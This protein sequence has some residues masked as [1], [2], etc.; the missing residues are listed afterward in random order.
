MDFHCPPDL[1]KLMVAPN[2]ARRTKHDHPAIP[3]TLEQT[4][5][6]A[7]KCHQAGA[8]SI[9]FHLRDD[10]QQHI[11]DA[12][13]Y[14]EGLAELYRQVPEMHLQITTEA[15]GRYNPEEMTKIAYDV[16]PP[17]ISIGVAELIPNRQPSADNIRLYK[18]LYEAGC[19]VQHLCYQLEDVDL[20]ARLITD[21]GSWRRKD[22]GHVCYRALYWPHQPSRYDPALYRPGGAD[23]GYSWIGRYVLLLN[24]NMP[25]WNRRLR[26]AARC[27]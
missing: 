2:G 17:G 24:R 11:L 13:L 12:G 26:W 21:A 4:V 8:E 1:P 20:L 15:V 6:T 25:H 27:G 16:M 23:M 7:K 9:H 3:V 14:K 5:E 22:L 18:T 19:R 10:K